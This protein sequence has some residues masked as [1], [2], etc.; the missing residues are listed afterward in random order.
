[1]FILPPRCRYFLAPHFTEKTQCP[2]PGRGNGGYNHAKPCLACNELAATEVIDNRTTIKHDPDAYFDD[3][4]QQRPGEI[5]PVLSC[6]LCSRC[7]VRFC[8]VSLG[9][10]RGHIR[11]EKTGMVELS[12]KEFLTRLRRTGHLVSLG[13]CGEIGW[14][15][16]ADLA[17]RYSKAENGELTW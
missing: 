2:G 3:P 6:K 7:G 1:M 10:M 16:V 4:L 13:S 5:L 12:R 11:N 15:L 8:S 14:L 17:N 9:L